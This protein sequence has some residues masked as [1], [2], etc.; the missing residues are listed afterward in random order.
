MEFRYNLRKAVQAASLFLKHNNGRPMEYMRLI[1][2]LYLADKRALDQMDET[3]TGD[4][5]VSMNYG[6][7]LSRIYDLI[8]HGPQGSPGDPWFDYISA[9]ENY[10]VNLLD[11]PGT[12]ELCEEEEEV[13]QKTFDFYG[14][15]DIWDLSEMTHL[16]PEWKNPHGSSIPIHIEEILRGMGKPEEEI[17]EIRA[18]IEAKNYLHKLLAID[19]DDDD[20]PDYDEDEKIEEI[21]YGIP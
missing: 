1:K 5:Y 21:K 18:D 13:I 10:K 9:P 4:R 12:D 19:D 17:E 8:N 16:F 11:D 20:C 7:V 6:P 14:S 2:L 15:I 3:I